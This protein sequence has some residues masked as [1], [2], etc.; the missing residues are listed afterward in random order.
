MTETLESKIMTLQ[1]KLRE[2]R[3]KRDASRLATEQQAQ[4][5]TAQPADGQSASGSEQATTNSVA[6]FSSQRGRGTPRGRFGGKGGRGRFGRGVGSMS[7]DC[8][9]KALVVSNIPDGF[10]DVAD[11]H[12]ARFGKVLAIEGHND[13]GIK[14]EFSSRYDAE[15]ALKEGAGFGGN[16]LTLEWADNSYAPSEASRSRGDSEEVS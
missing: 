12:F 6:R 16:M 13:S 9:P 5:A 1:F 8:R 2:V 15:R 11:Q 7:L 4:V 3:E 10:N 14:V